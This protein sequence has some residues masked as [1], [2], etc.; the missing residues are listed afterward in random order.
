MSGRARWCMYAWMNPEKRTCLEMNR[1]PERGMCEWCHDEQKG[2]HGATRQVGADRQSAA[3][4]FGTAPLVG[5]VGST[6]A[7]TASPPEPD[8]AAT[9]LVRRLLRQRAD[10]LGVDVADLA[11]DYLPVLQERVRAA[12]MFA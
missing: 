11:A 10:E 3:V 2:L 9:E 12:R 5:D 1:G 6:P 4:S 8:R 7:P